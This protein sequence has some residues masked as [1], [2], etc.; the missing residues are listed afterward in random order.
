MKFSKPILGL[1]Y[2]QTY[3]LSPVTLQVVVTL[4]SVSSFIQIM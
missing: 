1:I 3:I 2:E 4:L